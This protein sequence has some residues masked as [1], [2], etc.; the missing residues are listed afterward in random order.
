MLIEKTLLMFKKII[1]LYLTFITFLTQ[2]LASKT[3]NNTFLSKNSQLSA[4]F[5]ISP[6]FN[7]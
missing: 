2:N 7:A 1:Y 6:H 5:S 4:S 3:T